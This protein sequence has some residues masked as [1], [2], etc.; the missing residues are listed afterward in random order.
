MSTEGNDQQN[1]VPPKTN[2]VVQ[3]K[4]KIIIQQKT[5]YHKV[6]HSHQAN[7]IQYPSNL[8]RIPDRL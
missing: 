8:E 7:P 4:T 5:G 2:V 6:S 1:T 3:Q